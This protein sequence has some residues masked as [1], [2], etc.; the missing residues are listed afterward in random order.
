MLR[1]VAP[2]ATP[3][4]FVAPVAAAAAFLRERSIRIAEFARS[5]FA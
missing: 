1:F 5:I 2:A 4:R 3:L